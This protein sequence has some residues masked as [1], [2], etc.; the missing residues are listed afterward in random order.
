[1]LAFDVVQEERGAVSD[2]VAQLTGPGGP[3]EIVV[4]DVLGHP[5]QVYKTRMRSLRELMVQNAVRADVDWVVQGDAR[6]TFGEHDR[7]ARSL[8]AELAE[9]GVERGDRVALVSAN[10]PEWV[11]T[12]WAVAIL[13]A[14]LVPL[15][16]WWKAE[17]LEFGLSD[18]GAKVLIGDARRLALL[19]GPAGG[20]ARPGARVRDRDRRNSRRCSAGDDPG[21][22]ETPIDE[23]DLLAICYTSG[24]TGQPKGATLTHRQTIAN[25]QNIICAGCRGR[26]ARRRRRRKPKR[27]CSRLRCSSCRCSTSPDACRR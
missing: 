7:A 12:F 9:L 16:V 19:R 2:P 22:P 5:T 18:S 25:L 10:V 26:D 4:E 17:E 24:T 3:F 21:M 15:N 11:V 6:Y 8:A 14:T 20:A 1:M 23:D 27:R 13:G